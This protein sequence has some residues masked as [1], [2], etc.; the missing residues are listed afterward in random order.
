M[1]WQ[2]RGKYS[3]KLE[4]WKLDDINR[5]MDLLDVPRG[6]GDKKVGPQLHAMPECCTLWRTHGWLTAAPCGSAA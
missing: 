3:E 6:S 5:F 2:E 1:P 4:K